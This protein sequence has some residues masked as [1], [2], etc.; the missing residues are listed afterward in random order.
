MYFMFQEKFWKGVNDSEA[1]VVKAR[2]KYLFPF[3]FTQHAFF[4]A[5]A[6]CAQ[7]CRPLLLWQRGM[8]WHQGAV[9]MVLIQ[10]SD[11]RRSN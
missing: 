7:F 11:A 5:M 3:G 10:Q 2:K 6:A 1:D 4:V 9:E 8:V